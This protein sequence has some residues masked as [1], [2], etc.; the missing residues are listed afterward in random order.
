MFPALNV[1]R[2]YGAIG[3]DHTKGD[4]AAHALMAQSE[5]EVSAALSLRLVDVKQFEILAVQSLPLT[6]VCHS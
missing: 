2:A 1:V 6:Q 4:E 3:S 5:L